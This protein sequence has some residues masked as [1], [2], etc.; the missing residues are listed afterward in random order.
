MAP[1]PRPTIRRRRVARE[2]RKLMDAR[3]IKAARLAELLECQLPKVY[4]VL[5]AKAGFHPS[6]LKIVLR[7][8]EVDDE[9]AAQLVQW[10]REARVRGLVQ[11][12]AEAAPEYRRPY[13]GFEQDANTLAVFENE[14]VHGLLQTEDYARTV[15]AA[16]APGMA[17]DEVHRRVRLRMARQQVL[18]GDEPLTYW[19]IL[20]EAV[21]RNAV[22]GPKVMADQVFRLIEI[23]GLKNVTMQVLPFSAGAHAAMGS[24]FAILGFDEEDDLDLVYVEDIATSHLLEKPE[25]LAAYTVA[26]N[27]LRAAALSPEGSIGLLQQA[28]NEWSAQETGG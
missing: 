11:E 18:T 4:K 20:T 12:H 24:P 10:N 2:V 17:D 23:A 14:L 9:S 19:A 26:F 21:V 16:M 1:R 28:A 3:G 6:D 7:E 25:Q 13:L 8:L 5:G 15:T 22:G 27:R